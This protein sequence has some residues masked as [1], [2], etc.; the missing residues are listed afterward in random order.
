MRERRI[1]W[2]GGRLK[3]SPLIVSD[4]FIH[5]T[6]T[7]FRKPLRLEFLDLLPMCQ[8]APANRV[9]LKEF[10]RLYSCSPAICIISSLS[11][12]I[13]DHRLVGRYSLW[14]SSSPHC[15]PSL[16]RLRGPHCFASAHRGGFTLT[17]LGVSEFCLWAHRGQ[18]GML[19]SSAWRGKG[20]LP[21]CPGAPASPGQGWRPGQGGLQPSA[22]NA[23]ALLLVTSAQCASPNWKLKACPLLVFRGKFQ[24]LQHN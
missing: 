24:R 12:A 9:I 5:W 6:R 23:G 15:L 7:G 2:T 1:L 16:Q 19:I 3:N 14:K 20:A 13:S 4:V 11:G 22:P 18:T 10:V 17:P 8:P 21:R